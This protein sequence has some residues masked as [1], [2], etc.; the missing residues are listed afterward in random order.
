MIIDKTNLAVVTS[1]KIYLNNGLNKIDEEGIFSQKIFGPVK[2]WKCACGVLNSKILHDGRRCE[3]CGVLCSDPEIRYKTFAKIR[4]PFPFYKNSKSYKSKLDLLVGTNKNILDPHQTDRN[5]E[6]S[7]FISLI[8]AR[9]SIVKPKMVDTFIN[10]G[11][12][13]PLRITGI[14]SLYLALYVGAN[15]YYNAKCKDIVDNCFSYEL[16]VT[17]PKSRDIGIQ[18]KKG[19]KILT[20]NEINEQYCRILKIANFDWPNILDSEKIRDEFVEKIKLSI[21]NDDINHYVDD[22]Q[23]KQYDQM[24]SKYQSHINTIYQ[25]IISSLGTKTGYIRKDFIGRSIDFSA[26]AHIVSNPAL[27]AY[28]ITISKQIFLR[29]W[30]T[31]YLYYLNIIRDNKDKYNEL[32]P[33]VEFTDMYVNLDKLIHVNEFI[34]WMLNDNDKEYNLLLFINRQPTLW[35]YGAPVVKVVGVTDTDTIGMSNL[36]LEPLNADYDG[37]TVALYRVHDT[38]AQKEMQRQAYLKNEII[39]DHNDS[40]IQKIR[41]DG[42][43]PIYVLLSTKIDSNSE[44][45]EFNSLADIPSSFNHM[46][47]LHTP[48]KIN[49]KIYSY[50]VCLFNKWCDFSEIVVT[51]FSGSAIISKLI[52]KNSKSIDEYNNRMH[53]LSKRM[54]WFVSIHPELALTISLNEFNNLNIEKPKLLINKLPRNPH[55]GQHIYKYIQDE[56]Y[57]AI[58]EEY[59]LKALLEIK[60]NKTQ[61]SRLLCGI[62][63]IADSNNIIDSIPITKSIIGGLDEDTFFQTVSGTRKGITDKSEVTPDS[64][65]I[66]RSMVVNLSP[67]ELDKDD[68]GTILGFSIEIQSKSH[69]DSLRHKYYIDHNGYV[70]EYD[71]INTDDEVGKTYSF[72]SPLCCAND[73]FKICKICFGNYP[74]IKSKYVGILAGQSISERLTQLTMRTFHTSGSSDLPVNHNVIHIIKNNMIDII[75][76]DTHCEMIFSPRLTDNEVDTMKSVKGID[77]VRHIMP[78]NSNEEETHVFYHNMSNVINRDVTETIKEVKKLTQSQLTANLIPIDEVY[79]KF[80]MNALSVGQIY[81]TFVEIVLCNM[82][83][84]KTGEIWRI[85][86]QNDVNVKPTKKLNVKILHTIVSKLLGLLYEPNEKSICKFADMN[87]PLPIT[88]NTVLERFWNEL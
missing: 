49:N 63:Y 54:F 74:G 6:H 80:I 83:L 20:T 45:F 81:S 24:I 43:Y 48:I 4:L 86:L 85:A 38:E 60:V 1:D 51:K 29:L 30:F 76:N 71:P 67:I 33:Y 17:P 21:Q 66:E 14:Y 23:I 22:V 35:R 56:V 26:R 41:L 52:H 27:K 12:C 50:G 55:I 79:R 62:G 84:T 73:N 9:G 32:L 28:E 82:Y 42:I 2:P 34:N 72:R 47:Y 18:V 87:N 13:I 58:P 19:K 39:Y 77:Y 31:E 8:V 78:I 37:D 36:T 75:N 5:I 44:V 46:L 65:Y 11:S 40:Y 64:G 15:I 69:A 16:L 61:L 25:L 88:N 7:K 68:C 10:D 70:K 53:N 59:K 3:K 57:N